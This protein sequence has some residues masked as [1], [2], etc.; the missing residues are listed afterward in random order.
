MVIYDLEKKQE[1]KTLSGYKLHSC[2]EDNKY[3]Y[4]LNYEKNPIWNE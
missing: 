4:C 3:I 2:S 1:I